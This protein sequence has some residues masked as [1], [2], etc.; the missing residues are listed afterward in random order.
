MSGN[1][2][3]LGQMLDNNGRLREIRL[4]LNALQT[5]LS[6]QKKSQDLSGLGRDG[7]RATHARIELNQIDVF[8]SNISIGTTQVKATI[9]TLQEFMVQSKNIADTLA[10]HL[11]EGQ[12]NLASM[13]S[14]IHDTLGYLRELMNTQSDGKYILSGADSY[15]KPMND[16]GAHASY[17]AGIVESWR[18][19]TITTATLITSYQST[20]ETTMGYSASLSS[21]QIKN[22]YVRADTN[23]DIDYTLAADTTGFKKIINALALMDQ[24][25][26]DKVSIETDDPITTTTAPGTDADEQKENFFTLYE[27]AIKEINN[28]ISNLRLQEE[29]LQRAQLTLSTTAQEHVSDKNLLEN[30][31]GNIEEVDPAE[32]AVKITA[33]NTQMESAYQVTALMGSLSLAKY[34]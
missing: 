6:T 19:G 28:G 7:I 27:D 24:M 18:I 23:Q 8:Q 5:Q 25:N 31:L 15:T 29:R 30:I 2:S 33:L 14:S 13:K 12:V 20:P 4:Q 10:G 26:I 16:T 34:L 11:Q 1:V 3:T 9:N 21:N 17:M 32:V 22:I